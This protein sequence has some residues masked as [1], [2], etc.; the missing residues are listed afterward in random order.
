MA[1]LIKKT[2]PTMTWTTEQN[3][4]LYI[5][6]VKDFNFGDYEGDLMKML[7]DAVEDI[8]FCISAEW[9]GD[10]IDEN[11]EWGWGWNEEAK[12]NIDGIVDRVLWGKVED[13]KIYECEAFIAEFGM[14]QALSQARELEIAY[15]DL[16]LEKSWRMVVYAILKT[17]ID[18]GDDVKEVDEKD[19]EKIVMRSDESDDE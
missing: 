16:H 11:D 15:G 9:S 1:Y 5:K 13:L 8:N 17:G 18:L 7:D 10:R 6:D 19:F 3:T 2:N 14:Y 4:N 12:D